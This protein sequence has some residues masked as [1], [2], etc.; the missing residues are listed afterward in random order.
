MCG[1]MTW[2]SDPQ[3]VSA[4]GNCGGFGLLAGGH[5]DPVA[6]TVLV[7]QILFEIDTVPIFIAGG[8][9]TSRMMAHLLMMGTTAS[10]WEPDNRCDFNCQKFGRQV[11]IL[12][13]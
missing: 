11:S 1:A 3:L 10:R 9:A 6:L 5:I 12:N 13:P 2:V 8:I 7:L 4:V